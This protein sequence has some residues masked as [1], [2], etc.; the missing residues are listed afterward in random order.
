MVSQRFCKCKQKKCK[1]YSI[2]RDSLLTLYSL[3][4]HG[5]TVRQCERLENIIIT[6][7]LKF[8]FLEFL[9]HKKKDKIVHPPCTF[10]LISAHFVGGNHEKKGVP[11]LVKK[12]KNNGLA[13][14]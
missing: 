13:T 5:K 8:Y 4:S 9:K 12:E 10:P 7:F 2:K 3:S 6:K 1:G 11:L 14:C